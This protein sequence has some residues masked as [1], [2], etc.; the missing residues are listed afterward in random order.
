MFKDE[1]QI[2]RTA[3]QQEPAISEAYAAKPR[4]AAHL[5]HKL[6]A[7]PE[8]QHRVDQIRIVW[9][10]EDALAAHRQFAG[11]EC[12]LTHELRPLQSIDVVGDGYITKRELHSQL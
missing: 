7:V 11:L 8:L 9:S 1:P 2:I 12:N 10:P 3:V 5:V 6:I 4:V